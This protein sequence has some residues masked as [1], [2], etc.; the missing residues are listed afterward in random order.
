MNWPVSKNERFEIPNQKKNFLYN[1]SSSSFFEHSVI[2][3]G[4]PQSNRDTTRHIC[5]QGIQI[6]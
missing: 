5:S 1:F 3:G 2:I 6:H 4:I